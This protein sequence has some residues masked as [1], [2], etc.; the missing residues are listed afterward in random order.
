MEVTI[1]LT[2]G[3]LKLIFY[4]DVRQFSTW[5][6]EIDQTYVMIDDAV[7]F[8]VDVRT[9]MQFIRHFNWD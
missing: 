9:I 8:D 2:R 6:D 3:P 1:G 4:H 5:F 7:E